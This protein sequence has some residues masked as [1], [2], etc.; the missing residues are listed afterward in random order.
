[1]LDLGR[2]YHSDIEWRFWFIDNFDLLKDIRN[3]IVVPSMERCIITFVFFWVPHKHNICGP[4]A[5][6]K[7]S[8]VFGAII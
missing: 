1:M 8:K 3:G 2:V 6:V 5:E 7:K 4:L